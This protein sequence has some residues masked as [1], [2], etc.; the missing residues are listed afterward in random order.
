MKIK[1][2]LFRLLY[3]IMAALI[4][5]TNASS[6]DT[7]VDEAD[8][9]MIDTIDYGENLLDSNEVYKKQFD[10][11]SKDGEWVKAKKSDL[12]RD[13]DNI[14][15]EDLDF[16][17]EE[18]NEIVY[19][20]R[21]Y[22]IN[23]YWNP[24]YNG[25]WV[26][27]SYGWIWNSYYSWGWGPY[28]YGRWYFSNFHGWIWFP[29]NVWAPNWVTWRNCNNYAG[30]YPTCPRVYWRGAG[31]RICTNR[32]FTSVPRNWVFVNKRFYEEDR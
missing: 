7:S 6:Q 25:S 4:F 2:K 1:K 12:I 20:W 3:F 11:L 16:D 21:P 28:N 22:G 10:S 23:S 17:Y 15:E 27:T 29:G 9:P 26:F 13:L 24:Y 18:E 19:V 8:V 31:N 30:W 32:L 5:N 14:E